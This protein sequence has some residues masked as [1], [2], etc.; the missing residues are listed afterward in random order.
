MNEQMPL[1]RLVAGWMADEAA[2]APE[3][4]LDQILATTARTTPQ[5]SW[6]ARLAEPTLRRSGRTA[7]GLPNRSLVFATVALLL[8]AALVALVVGAI[9]LQNRPQ[10]PSSDDW[11]G[12]RGDAARSGVATQGPVGNPVTLWTAHVTGAVLEV[13]VIGDRVFFASDDGRL[14]ALSRD[15][16]DEEWAVGVAEPPLTGPFAADGRLYLSDA[17]GRFL[18]LSQTDGTT[19]W[20]T[21][22]TY[23]ARSRAVSAD[24]TLYFGTGDGSIVALDGATGAERWRVQLAGARN[25]GAPAIGGG[26][27]YAGTDGGGFVAVDID[28]HQVVWVGDTTGENT[29][30]ASV[31]DGIAYIGTG[32]DP[33]S[34][35][36]LHAFDAATGKP[37][38]TATD[39]FLS[40]PTVA[41][42]VAFTASTHGLFEAIDTASG[43]TL[44]SVQL[45]GDLRS[46][47]VVG[48]TVFVVASSAHRI[49]AVD[50]ATGDEL[51][52]YD[53]EGTPNCC[54]SVAR[55]AV[56]VGDQSGTVSAIGGDGA[57]IVGQPFA[58][59]AV[60]PGPSSPTDGP[61]PTPFPSIATVDWTTD[62]RGMGYAP[63]SQ[64]A[65][66]PQGR[67]WAPEADASRIAIFDAS[68]TF[69]EE[70]GEPGDRPGQFDF[71]RGNGD[72][73][74][75][76]A[77]ASDGSFYVL[78]VGNRRVQ[79]FDA[80]RRFVREWGSYGLDPRH[81]ADPVG[82]AVGPD[83]TV[84]VLDVIR[85]VVEHYAADG[86]VIGSFDPLADIPFSM[87]ANSLAIDADGNLYVTLAG[88]LQVA[89]FE[90]SGRF[91]RFIGQGAFAEQPTHTAIDGNGRLFVTQGPLRG[92]APGILAFAADGTLIG[93]FG[94]TGDGDGELVFPAGIALD[95]SGGLYVEDSLP[96]TA[97]LMRF[98]LTEDGPAP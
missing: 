66:D 40:L 97:R 86:T 31:M 71:T 18:A 13:S 19:I 74:G 6:R 21:T 58:S 94:P 8:L 56:F 65:V 42:G 10:E 98:E 82:I 9:L 84:W 43:R 92:A 96:E 23:P 93:G 26:R 16:G 60:S 64:I 63:I 25:V 27:I 53:L 30:S 80:Q 83:D 15:G 14:H 59:G 4:L 17:S 72:G 77:F 51:W 76:L 57:A 46:P 62:L 95:G 48:G 37:R 44:W 12:F 91:V 85:S 52:A 1:E 39:P 55:G 38:W 70:W 33:G 68:G 67:I 29:G 3:P 45:E 69:I 49:Y 28:S 11:L 79:Q 87:G 34:V 35:G 20:L 32:A 24:G 7:I 88:P 47:A 36:T 22:T 2:G 73:Y 61:T 50:A 5:P 81:Y 78:D 90:P 54:V 89:M 41:N 75:T